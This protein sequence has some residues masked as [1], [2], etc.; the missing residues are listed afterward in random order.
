MTLDDLMVV[1]RSQDASPFHGVNETLL[2]VALRQDEAK[3]QKQR[4]LM[5]WLVY[6]YSVVLIAGM[7]AFVVMM[8]GMIFF[9]DDDVII[10]WDLAI[11]IVGAAA[12]LFMGVHLYLTRRAQAQREQR[13]GDSLRDQLGRRI[14]QL[15]DELTRGTR[16]VSV[17]FIAMWLSGLA[18][19]IA[20]T[21]VNLEIS[22]PFDVWPAIVRMTLTFAVCWVISLWAV[23]R[24]VR[25]DLLPRKRR[26]EM[27]LKEFDG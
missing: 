16:Q 11:P 14:A 7:A 17:F 21:R 24:S 9:N 1:W 6:L 20:G 8:L 19:R 26:L 23:R 13:F 4:R 5:K 12:A 15:D 3:L 10:A 18:I 25:R 22:E 2:R 27:L